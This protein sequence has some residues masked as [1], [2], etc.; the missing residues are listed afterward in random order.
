MIEAP[1][2]PQGPKWQG[3][4]ER[5]NAYLRRNVG[6]LGFLRG[7]ETASDDGILAYDR[8]GPYAV[9]S[10]DGAWDPV[11]THSMQHGHGRFCRTTDADVS[12]TNTAYTVV[13]D[14]T[15]ES[16]GGV[17]LG[18]P[19]SRITVTKSGVYRLNMS[20]QLVT[21]SN[22]GY[23][24]MWVRKNGTNVDNS[25]RRSSIESSDDVRCFSFTVDLQLAVNDYVE[26][27]Y[28]GTTTDF[29]F[30][31][32]SA[33]SFAPSTASVMASLTLVEFDE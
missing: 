28:A 24:Y 16:N 5:M 29:S 4:A 7:G 26:V 33:T 11:V 20:A 6:R 15:E 12:A 1:P 14:T 23:M 27:M 30:E 31:A 18:T 9:L 32:S 22:K 19:A 10:K 17:A 21:D 8:D 2:P 13:F 3:W 25:N